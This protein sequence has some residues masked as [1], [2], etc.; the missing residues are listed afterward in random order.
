MMD[1]ELTP[2][3]NVAFTGAVADEINRLMRQIRLLTSIGDEMAEWVL[4]NRVCSCR[5]DSM[6]HKCRLLDRWGEARHG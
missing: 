2:L 1:N 3:A 5:Q 6:C 4:V